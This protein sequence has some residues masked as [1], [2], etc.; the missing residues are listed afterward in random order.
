M[1]VL[2][3]SSH[4][5]LRTEMVTFEIT[6]PVGF[7]SVY[8]MCR[9]NPQATAKPGNVRRGG[10]RRELA[11]LPLCNMHERFRLS[12]PVESARAELL[13]RTLIFTLALEE[14]L[15][16]ARRKVLFPSGAQSLHIPSRVSPKRRALIG[17]NNQQGSWLILI[18]EAA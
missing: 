16:V 5:W 4:R 3:P 10:T 15:S 9:S 18:S 8:W 14:C 17:G 1:E 2:S 13:T 6:L 11:S 7:V 12:W